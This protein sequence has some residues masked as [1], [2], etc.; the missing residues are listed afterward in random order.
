MTMRQTFFLVFLSFFFLTFTSLDKPCVKIKKVVP[1]PL[2]LGSDTE[3]R[4]YQDCNDTSKY[5][6]RMYR[7]D[8]LTLEG[9]MINEQKEGIWIYYAYGGP[10][11]K[12][13]YYHDKGIEIKSIENGW[14]IFII[15]DSLS[16][17]IKYSDGKIQSSGLLINNKKIGIWTILD[18]TEQI[19]SYGK[20]APEIICNT[21]TIYGK[22]PPYN[23]YDTIICD[24]RKDSTWFYF[25]SK[26]QL[27]KIEMY[28]NGKLIK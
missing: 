24:Q 26:N 4:E 12:K 27:I 15:N 11:Y 13:L 8:E 21:F 2:N 1:S 6:S 5:F 7:K 22:D 18:S 28:D 10:W 23:P 14:N 20:F 9:N 25:D 17:K 16:Y 3:K 19:K